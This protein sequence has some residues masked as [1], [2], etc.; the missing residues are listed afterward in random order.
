MDPEEGLHTNVGVFEL[1]FERTGQPQEEII[2]EVGNGDREM[3]ISVPCS[4]GRL[5][6]LCPRCDFISHCT[7]TGLVFVE[8]MKI[9]GA[10]SSD[11]G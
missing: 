5:T 10:A 8:R 7:C 9:N 1:F 3:R 4:A 11:A 2:G 6:A